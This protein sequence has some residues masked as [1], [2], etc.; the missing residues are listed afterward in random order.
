MILTSYLL[1]AVLAMMVA[2]GA[3]LLRA[4]QL[5]LDGYED[6]LGFHLGPPPVF[7]FLHPAPVIYAT[8]FAPDS[9]MRAEPALVAKP[10]ERTILGSK[11]PML[12]TDLQAE[13]LKKPT[14]HSSEAPT[15]S[16][17]A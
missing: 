16:E 13:D 14:G 10:E 15:G 12:P 11:P 7:L 8:P 6:E 9:S 2:G 3:T 1:I 5:A 4:I 17:S